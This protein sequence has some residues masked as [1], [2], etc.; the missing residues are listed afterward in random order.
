MFF[1]NLTLFR[2]SATVATDL[3]RLEEVL[4][5]HR[6]RPV[7]P[8]EM[9]TRGFISP[10]GR[11]EE[12]LVH[13]VGRNTMVT[14]GSEDKLLPSAVVNDEIANRVQKIV[15]E[16]GRKVSGRERKRMK[17]DVMNELLPRAFVRTSRMSG[18]VDKKNGWLV[19]DTSSRKSAENG[20]SQID[21]PAGRFPQVSGVRFTYD[22][23]TYWKTYDVGLIPPA[24]RTSRSCSSA[25]P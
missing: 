18:Y 12:A 13:M 17:D 16:E 15:D 8:M 19:L 21:H 24:S 25:A 1:R 2:F 6:L 5:E 10:L 11:K 7:G 3:D 9:F 4:P 23:A 14:V 20:V 22:P